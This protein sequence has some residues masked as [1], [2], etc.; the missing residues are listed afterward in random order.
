MSLVH[1]VVAYTLT[2]VHLCN[3]ISYRLEKIQQ[4]AKNLLEKVSTHY[5][6]DYHIYMYMYIPGFMHVLMAQIDYLL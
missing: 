6:R 4:Q 5:L 2:Y 1:A 3:C